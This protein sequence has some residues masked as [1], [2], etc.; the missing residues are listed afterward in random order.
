[1][2]VCSVR[3]DD[4]LIAWLEEQAE[5]KRRTWSKT[6]VLILEAER[7]RDMARQN[8]LEPSAAYAL[9]TTVRHA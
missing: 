5:R 9:E 8:R 7:K 4:D 2:K 6:L 3:M 1:M